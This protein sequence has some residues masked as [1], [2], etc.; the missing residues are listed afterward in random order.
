MQ[1]PID[2]F[3]SSNYATYILLT[4]QRYLGKEIIPTNVSTSECSHYK[5]FH[6]SACA[7]PYIDSLLNMHILCGRTIRT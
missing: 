7:L 6:T 1:I 5:Q 2:S 4:A 3:N